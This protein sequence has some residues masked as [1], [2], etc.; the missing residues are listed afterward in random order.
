MS[1]YIIALALLVFL[2]LL[3][4]NALA[5]EWGCEVLLCSAS[6]DPN[7]HGVSECHPPME[8]LISAMKGPGFSWP[9]CPE[10][11]AGK[12]GYEAYADCPTGTSPAGS[13]NDIGNHGASSEKSRCMRTVT[14]CKGSSFV[15]GNG[16]T[17][18]ATTASGVTR[19]YRNQNSCI[20]DEYTARPRRSEP[21][22]FDIED[23]ETKTSTRHYFDL[24]L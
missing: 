15:H 16:R 12:P 7:W 21:Y 19:V 14:S 1:R 8:K 23:S 22:Y 2:S 3:S 6:S 24:N 9:T 10:G 5:S 11:G 18:L 13:P 17:G 4:Q 20:F